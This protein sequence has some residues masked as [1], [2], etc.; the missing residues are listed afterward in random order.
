M[1]RY[2][3]RLCRAFQ[4]INRASPATPVELSDA[5]LWH[6]QCDII[7]QIYCKFLIG[8][9]GP[10]GLLTTLLVY[11]SMPRHGVAAE[12]L[13][14]T[15]FERA[16]AAF[17]ATETLKMLSASRKVNAALRPGHTPDATEARTLSLGSLAILFR[18][19][20]KNWDRSFHVIDIN[21]DTITL[22]QQSS[23][24][25]SSFASL[26]SLITSLQSQFQGRQ[27]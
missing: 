24:E 14:P 4:T 21:D 10:D 20:I 22:L 7:L 16:K 6:R 25:P 9:V 27:S 3:V 17:R 26:L 2:H 1:E 18:T 12:S 19:R 15:N 8:S 23:S 13:T 5:I 11:G